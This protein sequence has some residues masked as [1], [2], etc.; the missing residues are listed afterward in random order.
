MKRQ[1]ERLKILRARMSKV[2]K[3]IMQGLNE[4]FKISNEIGEVKD[5][6]DLPHFDPVRE[7]EMLKEILAENKGP[8][9]QDIMKRIFKEIFKASVEEMGAGTRRRLKVNR[10]PGSKDLIISVKG[11]DIGGKKPVLIAGPCSVEDHEQILRS[12]PAILLF[13]PASRR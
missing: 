12:R 9:P 5:I 4:F 13:R 8:M 3:E 1:S 7:S 6:M 2:N 11:I 10:L